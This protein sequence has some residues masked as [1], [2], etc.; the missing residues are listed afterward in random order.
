MDFFLE[1]NG[2]KFIFADLVLKEILW[3]LIFASY[4]LYRVLKE[5]FYK[6]F[7]QNKDKYTT[8]FDD[9][10]IFWSVEQPLIDK[11]LLFANLNP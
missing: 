1:F 11:I 6:L 4:I 10:V 2:E 8:K 5:I 3:E 7:C 9:N